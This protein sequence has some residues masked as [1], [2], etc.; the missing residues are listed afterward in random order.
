MT[1]TIYAEHLEEVTKRLDRIAKKAERYGVPFSYEVGE[2][3]PQEIAVYATDYIN[4]VQFVDKTFTVAAIDIDVECEGFVK[5]NGWKVLARIEHGDNGNIVT[6]FA[7]AEIRSEWYSAPARCDH[8]KT[9]RFRSVTF[10]VEHENGEQ[11]QVGHSCLKDYTGI[12]P[13]VALMWAETV[14]LFPD[15]NC[16]VS[17]WTERA[18]AI[19]Y[20]TRLVLA[21]AYDEIRAHGYVKSGSNNSTRDAVADKV[22]AEEVPSA[23]G[24][25]EAEKIITWLIERGEKADADNA[26][27]N[28]LWALYGDD[29]YCDD[30]RYWKQYRE[31]ANAWDAVSDLERNCV[32]LAR[33]G[34]TK[35]R[36]FGRLV[37]MPI[38]YK[39]FL[40]RKARADAREI[41]RTNAAATSHHVGSVGDRIEFVAKKTE[42]ITSWETMYGHT[43]LYKF[44][45]ESGNV[46]VWF[47][48]GAIHE[49]NGITVRGTVKKHDERDGIKQTV[50][51]R[52]KI[53]N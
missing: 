14:D 1:R 21:H 45:D 42:C 48:S 11:R 9:N 41:E 16:S 20:P 29:Q 12:S 17:E 53:A 25:A 22:R 38:A 34:Y 36:G 19:M 49:R 28:A 2:E 4:H 24:L 27:L 51:T 32:P 5:A 23:E 10:I 7:G 44:T 8:C 33:S 13:R 18:P 39:K 46:Y 37:Y 3:H 40:D 30:E 52:C 43:F 35:P 31:I 47:A 26:K 6:G 50:L 15:M